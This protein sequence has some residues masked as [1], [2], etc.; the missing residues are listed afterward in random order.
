MI[1]L[2]LK[3]V[4]VVAVMTFVGSV[5]SDAL[6]LRI[7]AASA[8]GDVLRQRVIPVARAWDRLATTP[9]M[10]VV[11]A[12]GIALAIE[13]HWFGHLW[14]TIKLIAVVALSGIHGVQSGRLRRLEVA[15]GDVVARGAT[16]SPFF[17]LSIVAI[18]I[19]FVVLK[20][21]G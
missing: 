10:A 13:G 1:Y 2:A 21:A 8:P 6:V 5:L 20:P 18:A 4:H 9:A 19:V 3:A 17:V 15:T 12:A 7:L 14:L 11:W 16:F